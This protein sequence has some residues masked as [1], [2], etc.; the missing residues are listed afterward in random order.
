[1]SGIR[2]VL[3]LIAAVARSYATDVVGY[4][5]NLNVIAPSTDME[6]LAIPIVAQACA[7]CLDT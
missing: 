5:G 6:H 1:M 3:S 4:E 7:D 2:M